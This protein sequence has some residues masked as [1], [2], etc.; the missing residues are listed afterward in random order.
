MLKII[1]IKT[2]DKYLITENVGNIGHFESGLQSF[3]F[4]GVQPNRMFKKNW[5]SIKSKPLKIEKEIEQKSIN[6]RWE[7]KPEFNSDMF[8]PIWLY[9]NILDE[10]GGWIE[11]FENISGLYDYKEDKQPNILQNIEFE[12]DEILEIDIFKEPT[13][14]SYK[15]SG[16][17]SSKTYPNVTEKNLK[18]DILSEVL[19]PDILLHTQPCKLSSK[20]TYDIIRNFVKENI[21]PRNAEIT[22]DYD[23]CFTVKK[24]IPLAKPYSYTVDVNNN[25]FSGKKKKPKYETR[26]VDKKS[27][28]IFEMAH[29]Q[30]ASN[31]KGYDGYSLITPFE[32]ENQ[33]AL[34]EY[35]DTYLETLINVINEQ[36]CECD[37]C[38]GVGV[39]LN[40]F[41]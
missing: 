23:F 26:L 22:S 30:A 27:I 41:K 6:K 1:A 8:K 39:L 37:K 9:E 25:I 12:W 2:N 21:N 4:D 13:G 33:D 38:D 29:N 32:A 7:L 34:K 24:K 31:G 20:N 18:Y 19:I 5:F 15:T 11:E 28:T 36:V 14:F 40:K 35:I 17:W 10:Y 3:Y 16:Q